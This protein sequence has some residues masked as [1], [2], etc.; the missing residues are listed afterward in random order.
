[1]QLVNGM[2]PEQLSTYANNGVINNDSMIRYIREAGGIG[3]FN[4]TDFTDENMTKL[5]EALKTQYKWN[6]SGATTPAPASAA[7]A[8]TP[9]TGG[10]TPATNT[11]TTTI[12]GDWVNDKTIK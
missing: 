5:N 9:A 1:M 11:F 2:T 10:T 12:Q 8:T 4:G 7:A 6:P 3:D